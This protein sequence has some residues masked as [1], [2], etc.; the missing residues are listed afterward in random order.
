M[1]GNPY[2]VSVRTP[3]ILDKLESH[4]IW[5]RRA[6]E[7]E[8]GRERGVLVG[9]GIACATKDYGTG[10]DSSLATRG[11]K[12]APARGRDARNDKQSTFL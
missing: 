9:T 10:A 11:L 6:Q 4:P 12:R 8:R 7:K 3:E 5:Q 2:T 1:T